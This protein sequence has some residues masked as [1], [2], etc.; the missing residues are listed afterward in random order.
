LLRREEK[1]SIVHLKVFCS[2]AGKEVFKHWN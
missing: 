2:A 1:P